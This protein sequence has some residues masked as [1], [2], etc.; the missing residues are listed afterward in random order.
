MSTK[1]KQTSDLRKI[2]V[3]AIMSALGF[4]LMY[5][6]DMFKIPLMP[7]FLKVDISELPALITAFAF[8]PAW[9]VGVCALKNIIHLLFFFGNSSGIGEL[10]NFLLG[11]PYVL[12]A[13]LVY[14]IHHDRK[15][16]FIGALLGDA[17]MAV[18]AFFI[19]WLIVYPLY[20][21]VM[22]IP[23]EAILNEYANILPSVD[24]TWKAIL[25]LNVPFTFIKGLLS[26][27]ITFAIYHNISPILKGKKIN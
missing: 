3:T 6:G 1:T 11:V 26:V 13:G 20:I 9:G 4:V 19:N 21:K 24:S 10:A 7:S 14:K 15:H 2:T 16:A 5:I 12:V 23:L 22:H 27:V 18:A 25:A 8:G 17:A